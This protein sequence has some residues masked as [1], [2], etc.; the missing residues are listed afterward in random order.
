ME[1]LTKFQNAHYTAKGEER[2]YVELHELNTLWL[3][4]GSICNL[5]CE[6]CYIESSPRNDRLAFINISDIEPVFKEIEELRLPVKLIGLTGGEPFANPHLMAILEFILRMGFD[7][8]ILTN[9]YRAI[10]KHQ[11]ALLGFHTMYGNRLKIRVSLDHHTRK[12][13]EQERG[14]GTFEETLSTLKWLV[15]NDFATSIAGR[16]LV[17]EDRTE[18]LLDYQTLLYSRDIDLSLKPGDNIVIFPEMDKKRDVPEIS[19]G[20]WDILK[21]SPSDQMCSTERMIVKKKGS[22]KISVMPCTLLAYD[23][24]FELGSTLSEAKTKVHLNHPFC[25]EFCV[26]GGASCS[27]AK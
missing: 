6:N 25:A 1:T 27:A 7:V 26:L 18:T 11:P 13:H 17:K 4:T 16:S 8:L 20:C 10:K 3:N 21:K 12:I 5:A 19:T 24:Q 9:G 23:E 22:D 14:E 2:A 15:D